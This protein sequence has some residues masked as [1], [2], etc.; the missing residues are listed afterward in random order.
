MYFTDE[1]AS[2]Q[3]R[4]PYRHVNYSQMN[5]KSETIMWMNL[6]TLGFT[7]TDDKGK[8][9]GLTSQA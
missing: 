5:Y 2:L 3:L 7:F 8:K 9:V 6:W 1:C 4:D